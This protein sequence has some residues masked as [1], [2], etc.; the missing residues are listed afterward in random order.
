MVNIAPDNTDTKE[1]TDTKKERL[2]MRHSIMVWVAGAVLGWVVAVA[3]VWTALNTT[4]SNMAKNDMPEAEKLQQ[5]LPAA[6]PS[7]E[8]DQDKPG[9]KTDADN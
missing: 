2:S 7:K 1:N 6:G 9:P 5:I 3:S 8:K 4:D